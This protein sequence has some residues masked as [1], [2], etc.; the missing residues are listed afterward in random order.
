[1]ED[2]PTGITLKDKLKIQEYKKNPSYTVLLEEGGTNKKIAWEDSFLSQP[3]P[4]ELI[5]NLAKWE[6][7]AER[8][9]QLEIE[10]EEEWKKYRIAYMEKYGIDPDEFDKISE[11]A[12]T[13]IDPVSNADEYFEKLQ[14]KMIQKAQKKRRK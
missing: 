9:K 11:E 8:R 10:R 5:D 12:D 7:E 4:Q 1:M 6:K 13:E 14:E 3:V 2:S